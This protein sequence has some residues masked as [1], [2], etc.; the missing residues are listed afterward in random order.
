MT[1]REKTVEIQK[2]MQQEG[3]KLAKYQQ[4]ILGQ[5][6]WSVLLRYE[7]VM[8][9]ASWVP[10]APGLFLRSKLY[11]G[12]LGYC[13]RNVTFG[14]DVVLRHPK[15]IFIGD[16][17]IIDDHCVL[18]A[19]GDD[20]RGIFIGDGVFLGRNTILNCKNGDII[21]EDHVNIGFNAMIFSASSVRVGRDNLVAAYCYLVGGTHAFDDPAVPVLHQGRSSNGI[22]IGPGGW[23]GAHVT[24]FDGVETGRHVVIGA[25]SVVNTDLPDYCVAG[26]VPVKIIKQRKPPRNRMP[27]P[28]PVT[29]AVINYNG[30]GILE[31]TL[32]SV[33]NQDYQA[34]TEIMVVDN[35]SSD[36]SVDIVRRRFPGVKIL[37]ME[38]NRG[39]NPA[40]NRALREA[41]S[42]YV[43]LMD[44]DIT[45]SRDTVSLLAEVLNLHPEAGIAGSQIRYASEPDRIQ[46]NGARIHYAGGAIQNKLELDNPVRVG[47]LPAGAFLV[48]R[49]KALEIGAFDE[50]YFY[51]WADGDFTFRMT[52]AGYHCL[53]VSRARVYHRKEKKGTPWVHYQVRN[54]WWFILKTYNARTLLV[55]MPAILV[56]QLA[57]FGFCLIK[58]QGGAYV[59]GSWGVVRTLPRILR[60]RKQVLKLKKVRDRDVLYGDRM[61]LMGDTGG[62]VVIKMAT[63][64]FNLVFSVY[65]RFARKWMK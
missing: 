51:G 30:A 16:N 61:D 10:G 14:R 52:L 9:M 54:R 23:L 7:L 17:V 53:N 39:P 12:L 3:G 27:V 13:G 43:L 21:L 45:L 35:A 8:G 28:K 64:V 26:G 29:V 25:G 24:V 31:E 65:W 58:G 63:A 38:E 55:A 41:G 40:R 44:N 33:L 6:K 37:R 50:D 22:R 1:A 57:I 42:E 48:N 5:R 62:G 46:Y 32:V 34:V 49:G 36:R 59:R 15:K 18:D 4:L 56:H 20:N 2:E 47:A 11:P 60:K 19:K